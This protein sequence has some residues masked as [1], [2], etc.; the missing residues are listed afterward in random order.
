MIKK[1][2]FFGGGIIVFIAGA[3]FYGIL[4]NVQ[5]VSLEQAIES[6]RLTQLGKIHIVVERSAYTLGLYSDSVLIK[7]YR[8]VFGSN[9]KHKTNNNDKATPIG[10]YKICSVDTVHKY[11]KLF[12]LNYP[13]L[14]DAE[15]GLLKKNITQKEYDA[16]RFEFYYGTCTNANTALGGN[17]GI[18]GMG[19]LDYLIKNLPFVFNWTDGSIAL[20]NESIDELHSIIKE[21]TAVVIKP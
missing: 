14:E 4:L 2:F 11:G 13:N 15:E 12:K 8:A 18:H 1:I 5:E 7:N 17:I 21:G 20:C 16:L 9:K 10:N 3:L 19:K 6:K